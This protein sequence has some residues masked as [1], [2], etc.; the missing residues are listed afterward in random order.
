MSNPEPSLFYALIVLT[1]LIAA[2]SLGVALHIM[3]WVKNRRRLAKALAVCSTTLA[4]AVLLNPV[5]NL[6][7][8]NND[9]QRIVSAMLSEVGA[10]SETLGWK[11]GN[12]SRVYA[13]DQG[14]RRRYSP[15]PWYCFVPWEEV[16]FE[17]RNGRIEAAFIDD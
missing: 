10:P 8:F 6:L 1:T 11:Y 13:C 4:V 7:M 16:I 12:P 14:E 17:I 2:A 5:V 15:G 9:R 3:L